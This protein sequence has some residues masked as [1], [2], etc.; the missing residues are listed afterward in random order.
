MHRY[1]SVLGRCARGLDAAFLGATVASAFLNL[2]LIR[3]AGLEEV[4]LPR[5]RPCFASR[6]SRVLCG[7]ICGPQG[8]P[9]FE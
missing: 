6:L 5:A 4:L 1:G 2:L 8:C 3:V 7:S 9:V